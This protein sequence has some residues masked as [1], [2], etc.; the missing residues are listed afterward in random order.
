M[1]VR[2]IMYYENILNPSIY[3]YIYINK[4]IYIHIYLQLQFYRNV[5]IKEIRY[6][7]LGI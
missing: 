6:L 1:F 3:I 7:L 4:H 2:F 5:I